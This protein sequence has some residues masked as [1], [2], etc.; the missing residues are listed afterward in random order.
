MDRGARIPSSPGP[1]LAPSSGCPLWGQRVRACSPQHRFGAPECAGWVMGGWCL[2][3]DALLPLFSEQLVVSGS[4]LVESEKRDNILLV[5]GSPAA[6]LGGTKHP[7][8]ASVTS[9][10]PSGWWDPSAAWIHP[11][12]S[13]AGHLRPVSPTGDAQLSPCRPEGGQSFTPLGL[14]KMLGAWWSNSWMMGRK[15][16][17]EGGCPGWLLQEYI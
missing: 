16:V 17:M 4:L 8:A 9:A 12:R 2:A 6:R 5:R 1:P 7:P 11:A 13:A 10:P 15:G 3:A 14:H